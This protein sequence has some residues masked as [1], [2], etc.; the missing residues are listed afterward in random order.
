VLGTRIQP[1][2]WQRRSPY[3]NSD[4]VFTIVDSLSIDINRSELFL[5][6]LATH[7]TSR[8]APFSTPVAAS[9]PSAKATMTPVSTTFP[10]FPYPVLTPI[11]GRPNALSVNN[12]ISQVYANAGSVD[13]PRGGG[14]NGCLW[15]VV[16]AIGYLVF[17]EVAVEIPVPPGPVPATGVRAWEIKS[18]EFNAYRTLLAIIRAQIVAAVEEAYLVALRDP[19]QDYNNVSIVTMLGHL[20]TTYGVLTQ[21]D[22]ENNREQLSNQWDPT[23]PIENLWSTVATIRS[24]DPNL[25]DGTVML[26]TQIALHKS[27]VFNHY[28][29]T[30]R[31]KPDTD[32]TWDNFKTHFARAD[33]DRKHSLTAQGAGYHGAHMATKGVGPPNP[34]AAAA[35]IKHGGEK[36]MCGDV[37]I[38]YCWTHGLNLSH[39][40]A[41]CNNPDP[42]HKKTATLMDRESGSERVRVGKSGR[43]RTPRTAAKAATSPGTAGAATTD[44]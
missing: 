27:G 14:T 20:Q 12:L 34:I 21:M 1:S 29:Q 28:L 26:K 23:S 44:E 19:L 5:S 36:V 6:S 4:H 43:P 24:I 17:S 18:A 2:A 3:N 13:S 11:V 35:G 31:D 32:Q 37:E 15:A 33:I 9:A 10:Q 7:D 30:W 40:S 41:T 16:S 22:L 25:D 42:G 8:H 38:C 39:N